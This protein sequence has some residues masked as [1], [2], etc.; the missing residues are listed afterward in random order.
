MS[1]DGGFKFP[2]LKLLW[3]LIALTWMA[4]GDTPQPGG[5]TQTG[6]AALKAMSL[7]QL[8]QIEVTTPSKEPVKAFRSPVAIFVITGEDIRRSGATS[9]PEALRLVP[10]VE[11][12]RIDSSK[13]SVGIRGFGTRL[14]RAVLVLIDGRSVYTPLFAGTYWEVQDTLLEDIDRIEVIRGPGGA[15]WGPNAVNGVINIITKNTKDTQGTYASAGGGNEDQGFVNFRYGGGNGKGLTYRIYAKGYTRAPEY[16]LNKDNFDDW[17]G[18]QSGFRMDWAKSERDDFTV[19]GDIYKEEDGERVDLGNYTPP[20]QRTFDGN[21]DLS[22]GNILARW[23]RKLNDDNSFQI[24]TYYDRTNRYEPNLGERRDTFDIDFIERTKVKPRQQL[25]YG[26]GARLSDGRFL[27]VGS[28][29]VFSPANNLD[30]LLSG[31]FEDDITVINRKLLLTLGT[32]VLGTNYTAFETEPSI[33]LL[34]TPSEKHTFWAAFTHSIRTPSRVEH[35]FYLSSYLGSGPGGVPLFARFDANPDFAPEQLNGYELGYRTL[36][37]KNFFIDFA[38]FWNHYHDLFSQDLAA[39]PFT[40]STL[41]FPES[42]PPP[43][44]TIITAQFRNDLFGFTTGGEIAPEWRPTSFWRLRASYS[45]LNMNL[46]KAPGTALGGTPESIVG[47]SP[48][49]EAEA[50]SSFDISKKLQLDLIYR[51]VS[52][53]P[54]VS[55]PAYSTGDAR[56]AWRFSP[57]FE[58]S[59]VGRNLFQPQHIEYAA[60]PGGPVAIRRSAYASLAWTK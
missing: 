41:P 20:S 29:L 31:F 37:K 23:T 55:A 2:Q 53:L 19:Q 7:E 18:A 54:A 5:P 43:V 42:A 16:H 3:L 57:R 17:R 51:Y 25:I 8:S 9:I 39:P 32:K 56:L 4:S 6:P 36:I 45:F 15:I 46:S 38:G 1:S 47:S 50:Q 48:R 28:G 33:R 60:D 27:E 24:Q 35:D 10:G 13:W 12:A 14:S 59:V 22:G 30:Y 11:V 49:H 52:A 40:E 21:A 58:L 44:H 34:W 26:L